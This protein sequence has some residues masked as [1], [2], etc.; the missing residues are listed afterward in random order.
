MIVSGKNILLYSHDDGDSWSEYDFEDDVEIDGTS[1]SDINSDGFD[2]LSV[3]SDKGVQS[4]TFK[5]VINI[6]INRNRNSLLQTRSTSD[7]RYLHVAI[8]R[9]RSFLG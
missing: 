4:R 2:V 8:Q 3:V 1:Y 6:F 7:W 9:I 5:Y